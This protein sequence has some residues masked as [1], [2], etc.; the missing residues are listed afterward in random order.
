MRANDP[1]N[2]TATARI[3]L[4]A[5]SSE[6]GGKLGSPL[7]ANDTTYWKQLIG[8]QK[9]RGRIAFAEGA[10]PQEALR[11]DGRHHQDIDLKS[12]HVL[13]VS[14]SDSVVGAARF[15]PHRPDVQFTELTLSHTSIL[16]SP[17]WSGLFQ[18]AVEDR[19]RE[20]RRRQVPIVELGGWVITEEARCSKV[21]LEMAISIVSLADAL[22]GAIG[23]STTTTRHG[24]AAMMRKLG[25]VPLGVNGKE[26]PAY[27]DSTYQCE[28]QLL[29]YDSAQPPPQFA[30]L[31]D[32]M[33]KKLGQT[34]VICPAA[35]PNEQPDTTGMDLMALNAGIL[36]STKLAEIAVHTNTALAADQTS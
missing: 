2:S 17:E 23:L 3:V 21:A 34:P 19:L 26:I 9:L 28:I 24:S 30:P 14:G 36:K 8:L 16:S 12:W 31:L 11:T 13:A 4:L 20:A 29:S 10:I 1:E 35:R 7:F 15:H 18:S 27:F 5:P 22:G 32:T 33:R 25:G 6:A